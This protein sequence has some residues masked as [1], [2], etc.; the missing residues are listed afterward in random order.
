MVLAYDIDAQNKNQRVA[1]SW[2]APSTK[3]A[4][5]RVGKRLAS[6]IL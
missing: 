2:K 4:K 6:P 1:K 3:L 5:H